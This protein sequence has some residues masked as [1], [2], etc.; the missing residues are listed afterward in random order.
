[1]NITVG[2]CYRVKTWE[3]MEEEYGLNVY[4][5]ID[6]P[7]IFVPDM[8]YLCNKVVKVVSIE[9]IHKSCGFTNKILVQGENWKFS[10]EMLK[11]FCTLRNILEEKK[12]LYKENSNEN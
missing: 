2:G 9:L 5:N 8:K 6:V 4:G 10:E 7:F 3:E 11:P 12:L 1:M